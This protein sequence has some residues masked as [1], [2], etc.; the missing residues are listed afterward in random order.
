MKPQYIENEGMLIAGNFWQVHPQTCEPWSEE[1]VAE[2]IE[3]YQ[4]PVTTPDVE[5]LVS[6]GIKKIKRQ[7][8]ERIVA[9]DWKLQRAEERLSQTELSGGGSEALEQAEDAVLA[10]LDERDAIRTQS[11]IAEESLSA[12][13]DIGEIE[14]FTW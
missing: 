7:A 9:L 1:T 4:V 14:S 13:T 2:F 12:L 5:L 11:N 3:S 10:I 6:A 8:A